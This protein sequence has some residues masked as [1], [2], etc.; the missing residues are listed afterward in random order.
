M[1]NGMEVVDEKGMRRKYHLQFNQPRFHDL[2]KQMGTYWEKDDHDYRFNDADP[3]QDLDIPHEL[4]I[5]NF[6]EQLPVV[7]PNDLSAK[8]YRTFRMSKDLQ[9]WMVEGRDYRSANNLEDGP[10]KT[11]WGKEQFNWL[12][13]SLLESDATFKLL[14]SPT[15]MV[16]PDMVSFSEDNPKND[17]PGRSLAA[18]NPPQNPKM[19]NHKIEVCSL[20]QI[21]QVQKKEM[22]IK[23][24][25]KVWLLMVTA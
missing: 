8:T 1:F 20:N 18:P 17:N 15:P 6:R 5:K 2:F 13:K 16:G 23:I 4:G 3:Y 22:K 24:A 21:A 14:I 25:A 11:I 10:D 12:K 7:D 19:I 9:I